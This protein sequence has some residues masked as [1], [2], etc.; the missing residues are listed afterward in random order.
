MDKLF[1]KAYLYFWISIPIIILFGFLKSDGT[2][3]VDFYD[4][5]F[6][7]ANPYLVL[8]I[9]IAFAIIGFWY[10]L[11]HRIKRNLIKWMTFIHVVVTI[12]GILIA[13]VIEQ[14]F[15]KSNLDLEYP[16]AISLIFTI[17][18]ILIFLVQIVFPLNLIITLLKKPSN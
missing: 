2:F 8:V 10:W 5:Y 3:I 11:M 12:D 17:I 9:S 6:V 15:R 7:I 18:L 14:F 1:N 13:F 16:N 4:T